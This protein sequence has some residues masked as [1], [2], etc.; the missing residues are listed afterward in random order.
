MA[1]AGNFC[2]VDIEINAWSGCFQINLILIQYS[3]WKSYLQWRVKDIQIKQSEL[4]SG[5]SFFVEINNMVD[6]LDI[7]NALEISA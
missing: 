4:G 5:N 6:L 2:I 7:R 1:V 3:A